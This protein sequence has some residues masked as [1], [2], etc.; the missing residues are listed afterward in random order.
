MSALDI[1]YT[2]PVR[3]HSF[4]HSDHKFGRVEREIKKVDTILLPEEY[5]ILRKLGTLHVYGE[6]WQSFDFKAA[7]AALCKAQRSFKISKVKVLSL[8]GN[9]ILFK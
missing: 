5:D 3:G 2:L 1:S 7:T 9:N 4:L 8:D 6:D